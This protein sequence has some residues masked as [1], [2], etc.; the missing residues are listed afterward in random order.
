MAE[1]DI[2]QVSRD[3]EKKISELEELRIL[4]RQCVRELNAA[5]KPMLDADREYKK[6]I[7]IT[8][9][10][11]LNGVEMELAGIK[12][13]KPPATIMI[14]VAEAI[15]ADEHQLK[16]DT[17]V[18]LYNAAKNKVVSLAKE[19]DNVE[20]Q[21]TGNQSLFKSFEQLVRTRQ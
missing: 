4:S 3:I 16:K 21:L 15:C 14:K 2:Y 12:V 5:E 7:G 18:A 13:V 8:I 19:M 20:Y 6:H 10:K 11:L 1:L 17:T 9:L